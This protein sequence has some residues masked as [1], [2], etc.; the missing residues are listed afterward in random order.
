M[1]PKKSDL[2]EV[3]PAH[4][5]FK[6]GT[7]STVALTSKKR[8]HESDMQNVE[9]ENNE[10]DTKCKEKKSKKSVNKGDK[11][12][13]TKSSAKEV[14]KNIKWKK[15]ITSALELVRNLG[16]YHLCTLGMIVILCYN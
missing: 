2:T 10:D 7:E 13:G 4:N 16:L 11:V 6:T 12:M 9:V 5:G 8:K 3:D 15:L 1:E 14:K